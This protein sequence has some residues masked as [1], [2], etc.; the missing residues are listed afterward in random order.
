LLRRQN[1][2][3]TLKHF[4]RSGHQAQQVP[5]LHLF[6]ISL[7]TI[8]SYLL[9]QMEVLTFRMSPVVTM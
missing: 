5:N 1:S 7:M 3:T 2:K 4:S 8:L 9:I 6:I